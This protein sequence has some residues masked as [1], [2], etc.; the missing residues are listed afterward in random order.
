MDVGGGGTTS[1]PF[2][3]M[4]LRP[5][6]AVSGRSQDSR[7]HERC[8]IECCLHGELLDWKEGG[9]GGLKVS[10]LVEALWRLELRF[11]GEVLEEAR[12]MYEMA[13]DL[14]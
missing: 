7:G 4:R 8:E 10:S 2:E 3:G 14:L 6:F 11:S 9:T 12:P 5:L 13:Q 1:W